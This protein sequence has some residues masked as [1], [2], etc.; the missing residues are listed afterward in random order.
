M[1]LS[2]SGKGVGGSP[3]FSCG[4]NSTACVAEDCRGGRTGYV[5]GPKRISLKGLVSQGECQFQVN[6]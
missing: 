1:S 5:E 4:R 2:L 3:D 6:V